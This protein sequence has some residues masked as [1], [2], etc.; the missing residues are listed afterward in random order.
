MKTHPPMEKNN[1]VLKHK[2]IYQGKKYLTL[3]DAVTYTGM[4]TTAIHQLIVRSKIKGD[5][6]VQRNRYV[7]LSLSVCER[8]KLEWAQKL[9]SKKVNELLTLNIP[10]EEIDKF[11]LKMKQRDGKR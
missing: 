2:I 11:L 10:E 1:E 3:P 4:E 9:K 6:V 5:D 7:Y 8:L